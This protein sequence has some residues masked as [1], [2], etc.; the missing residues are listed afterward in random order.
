MTRSP[1]PR[2][3]RT[4]SRERDHDPSTN[5]D[6][7][8]PGKDSVDLDT[9][10]HTAVPDA[11][12]EQAGRVPGAA[13]GAVLGSGQPRGLPASLSLVQAAHA[14]GIGRTSA[15]NLAR[16]GEFPCPLIKVG[17]LYRVPTAGLL[18]LL[19]LTPPPT[20]PPTQSVSPS[21]PAPQR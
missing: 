13:A 2:R 14:L 1:R 5:A 3:D 9:V 8:G 15:Y 16:R 21:P 6:R 17:A 20:P 4:G 12:G 7:A 10:L 19:G 18:R 11:G